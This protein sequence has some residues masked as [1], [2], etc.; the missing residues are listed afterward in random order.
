MSTA[1]NTI[2]VSPTKRASAPT[3][4]GLYD[5]RYEH[6]ACGVGFVV[7]VKGNKSHA[8]VRQA[9][10]ILKN[11][12]HRGATGSEKNTGDGAGILLQMPHLFL[13]EVCEESRIPLPLL[14]EYGT[15]MVF[16]PE[17][18]LERRRAKALFELIVREEGQTMLGWRAVPLNSSPLGAA[19]RASEPVVEQIFIGRNAKIQDDMAFERKLYV[20]RRRAENAVRYA[21]ATG[22]PEFYVVSL[23]YKTLIYKGMLMAEQVEQFYPELEDPAMQSALALVHQRFQYQHLP[24]LAAGAPL[25]LCRP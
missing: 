8:I 12:R 1:N 25:P 20:I 9:L 6:D 11:L 23:S 22:C 17:D 2:S 18:P 3:G 19:A 21:A 7:N 5:P 24:E 13:K 15:G 16:L 4:Q 14:T 10:T